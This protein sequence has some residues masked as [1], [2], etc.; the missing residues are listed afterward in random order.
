MPTKQQVIEDILGA[1]EEEFYKTLKSESYPHFFGGKVE[2][3]YSTKPRLQIDINEIGRPGPKLG[4]KFKKREGPS[5]AALKAMQQ[6]D[7]EEF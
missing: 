2:I 1:V 3:A 7:Q 5:K 6:E 4:Q